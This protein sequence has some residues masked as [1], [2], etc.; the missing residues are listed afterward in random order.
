MNSENPKDKKELISV[1]LFGLSAL[2]AVCIF[3]KVAGYF[4]TSARAEGL[5]IKAGE[6]GELGP[7]D[8]KKCL[9][10]SRAIADE[11]KEKNLFVPPPP[12]KHPVKQV[13]GILGDEALLFTHEK[14]EE[15]KWYKVGDMVKDAKIVAIEPT[16]IKIKW[17]GGEIT[18]AP[19]EAVSAGPAAPRPVPKEVEEEPEEPPQPRSERGPGPGRRGRR[20]FQNLSPEERAALRERMRNMSDEEREEFRAEMRERFGS[21]E[22][23]ND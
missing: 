12:K 7:D 22:I 20:M 19:I 1:V 10:K 2:L 11:L 8:V 18:L 14:P 3:V 5:V 6:Q 15:G 23:E 13:A 16:Q 4:V 21:E 9:A 17:D